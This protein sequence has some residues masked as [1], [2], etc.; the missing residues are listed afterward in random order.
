MILKSWNIEQEG[1]F[2]WNRLC[3]RINFHAIN[4]KALLLPE[5]VHEI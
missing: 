2:P 3:S 5:Q 1:T 4:A